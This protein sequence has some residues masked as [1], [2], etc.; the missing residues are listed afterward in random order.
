MKTGMGVSV[1]L[2]PPGVQGH[3]AAF[4]TETAL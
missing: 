2:F 4:A 3:A 1:R